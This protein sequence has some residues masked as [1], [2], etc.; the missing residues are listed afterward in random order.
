MFSLAE[1][2]KLV[3]ACQR[4]DKSFDDLL[5][6]LALASHNVH[7]WGSRSEVQVVGDVESVLSEY[8]LGEL[9]EDALL[10]RI[11]RVVAS[12]APIR[13]QLLASTILV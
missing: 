12:H 3:S 13:F 8:H 4:G 1:L 5:D 10:R 6:W 11:G 9:D 2:S 7:Q